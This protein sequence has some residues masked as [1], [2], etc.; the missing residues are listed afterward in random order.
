MWI[1][2]AITFLVPFVVLHL[3]HVY[4]RQSLWGL[5]VLIAPACV[6]YT[7]RTYKRFEDN[8]T[9]CLCWNVSALAL[10]FAT[11]TMPGYFVT[12]KTMILLISVKWLVIGLLAL[13]GTWFTIR[14][15]ERYGEERAA[16]D[17]WFKKI[18]DDHQD[19]PVAVIRTVTDEI[20]RLRRKQTLYLWLGATCLAAG[21]VLCAWSLFK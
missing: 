2:W 4:G 12:G 17:K 18:V 1:A 21:T 20:G 11:A 16:Y 15:Q 9:I 5:P 3:L 19:D 13:Y 14:Q 7:L 10:G 8:L 6:A